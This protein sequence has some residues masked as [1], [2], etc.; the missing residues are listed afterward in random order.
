MKKRLTIYSD[1]DNHAQNKA[2]NEAKLDKSSDDCCVSENS[3]AAT[4][5]DAFFYEVNPMKLYYT[6]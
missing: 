4:K 5:W 3:H 6:S 1:M 2:T